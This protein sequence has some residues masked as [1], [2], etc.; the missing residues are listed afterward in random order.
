LSILI[1]FWQNYKASLGLLQI[2]NPL[3][4]NPNLSMIGVMKIEPIILEGRFVRLEPLSMLHYEQLCEV[5]LD[6]DLWRISPDQIVTPDDLKRYLETALAEQNR[7][8]SLP[9]ATIEK[10]TNRAIGSTRFGNLA[11]KDRRTEIGWTWIGRDWQRTYVNTEAKLLMLT[12]A[13]ETWECIRVE[14]KTDVLN[15]RSRNAILRL[16]ATQEGIFRQHI[17]CQS[18]RLRDSVYFSILD[19]EWQTVKA[20][21]EAKLRQ[22]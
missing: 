13:F 7:G 3:L 6:E 16:G 12:H 9:F 5:G 11:P 14:F 2:F 10:S 22:K 20:N 4:S 8:V 17:I 18:G 1:E 15:E 19:S 21:L